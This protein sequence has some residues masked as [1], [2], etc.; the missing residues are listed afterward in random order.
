VKREADKGCVF[1]FLLENALGRVPPSDESTELVDSI[2]T[3][4]EALGEAGVDFDFTIAIQYAWQWSGIFVGTRDVETA[5][6]THFFR[7]YPVDSRFTLGGLAGLIAPPRAKLAH[8]L[9]NLGY[10]ALVATTEEPG[11][12]Y[13]PQW[14]QVLERE[15]KI[16]RA[17][18]KD[19]MT[20]HS[21]CM[22]REI[23]LLPCMLLQI[24]GTFISPSVR[25]V[26]VSDIAV[27]PIRYVC[28]SYCW[29]GPQP[30]MTV[31]SRVASY[32][33]GIDTAA[34]PMTVLD[35]VRVTLSLGLQYMWVDAFCIVQDS[36]HEKNVELNKMSSI[37]AGAVCTICAMSVHAATEGFLRP[38]GGM[39]NDAATT[40][41]VNIRDAESDQVAV[42]EIRSDLLQKR[43]RDQPLLSRAW[44]FQEALL[45]PRLI[46]FFS[47]GQR[48][49]FRCAR[50][51]LRSDGGILSQMPIALTCMEDMIV[52][53]QSKQGGSRSYKISEEW[54]TLVKL[55][56]ERSV[57]FPGDRLPA[58]MGIVAEWEN[59]LG[60]G[61][62]RAGLWSG[63]IRCDLLWRAERDFSPRAAHESFVAPSWSWVSRAHPVDYQSRG[64]IWDD[65]NL[66]RVLACDVTPVDPEVPNGAIRSTRLTVQCIS[67][68]VKVPDP[69][70]NA[71]DYLRSRLR[72]SD[73]SV[74]FLFDDD[75]RPRGLGKMWL[76]SIAWEEPYNNSHEIGLGVREVENAGS[77][78]TK[79][80]VRVGMFNDMR[81]GEKA[82][83][84]MRQFTII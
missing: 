4:L 55:Y 10:D 33:G 21:A 56:A 42:L 27:R 26:K 72:T 82:T 28:L 79:L 12:Q 30:E 53:L 46:M 18:I 6:N 69:E 67:E 39:E 71:V 11:A 13:D 36:G 16:F 22:P 20:N 60:L 61:T 8:D 19:C 76:L 75:P 83:G 66:A 70:D 54:V 43:T 44:T 9:N 15:S 84:P 24:S 31:A 37:Y 14:A 52:K 59:R 40:W 62:Y 23:S 49:V 17:L 50:S 41:H 58:L 7:L 48:P 47:E 73:G 68:L 77:G 32:L 34:F 78:D 64:E 80:Y 35:A 1:C 5:V 57:T 29:G 25:L 45:S 74:D 38:A 63:T 81:R 2:Q 65:D 51:A 3:R